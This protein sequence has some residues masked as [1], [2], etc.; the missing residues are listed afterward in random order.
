MIMSVVFE[1]KY[2]EDEIQTAL[3][4][5][6]AMMP[7]DIFKVLCGTPPE[8]LVWKAGKQP[9]CTLYLLCMKPA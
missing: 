8:K 2:E 9:Y 1:K 5:E 4:E 6:D 3:D 7:E